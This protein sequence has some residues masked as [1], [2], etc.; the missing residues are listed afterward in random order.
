MAGRG[1]GRGQYYKNLYGRG[2][3]RGGDGRPVEDEGR[4]VKRVRKTENEA[5]GNVD[6]LA[7]MLRRLD[8][9][10]YPAY[11]DLQGVWQYPSG[12]LV[13]DHIQGDPFAPASKFRL[14]ATQDLIGYDKSL[15]D[16]PTREVALR[17]YLT[18]R[19]YELLSRPYSSQGNSSGSKGWSTA[20]RG[21]ISIDKP[22]QQVL[23]RSSV[24]IGEQGFEVRFTISL[25]ARGRTILGHQAAQ[26]FENDIPRLFN[27]ILASSQPEGQVKLFVDCIDDQHHL[28]EELSQRGLVAFVPNGATLPRASGASDLPLSGPNVVRLQS[29]PHLEQIFYLHNSRKE[30][31]GMVIPAGITMIAG[32]GFHG[33]STL[34]DALAVGCYNHIPGDGREYLVASPRILSVQGEDGRSIK[35]VDISPFISTLPGGIST[36]SFSTQDASGSTS[37]AAGVIEAV[38]T[39]AD[40]LLF[41]EDTCATNFLIR[42]RRMQR[43]ITADPITPLIFK[44]RALLKDHGVSSVLV[45]GGCGDY[46]DVA[47]L[48]LEMRNYECHDI[49]DAARKVAQEIPSVVSWYEEHKFG[50]VHGRTLDLSSLPSSNTKTVARKRTAIDVGQIH[51]DLSAAKQLVHDS[52]TRAIAAALKYLASSIIQ[53][54]MLAELL[55]NLENQMD[56]SGLDMLVGHERVDGFLARPRLFEIAMAINR[57]RSVIIDGVTR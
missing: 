21:V 19:L 41:D 24:V 6:A 25:P 49:T 7:Q 12:L 14:R 46:C 1:S 36:K 39:G 5:L 3:G 18:R 50:A 27:A 28:R 22:G 31:R 33:K 38:E 52:Q 4:G 30:I 29:P 47:D 2:K 57:L 15:Y 13:V 16:N 10:S 32:G 54:V 26:I 17:D 35:N 8:G 42:D 48:V 45:I 56:H 34:L 11:H 20:K 9:K 37:M 40:T 51:L 23:E 55:N 43:L 44:V 53:P